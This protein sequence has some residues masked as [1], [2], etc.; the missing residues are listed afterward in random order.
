M[1]RQVPF[2][3][4]L[5][6]HNRCF[7]CR[8]KVNVRKLWNVS[9]TSI[10]KALINHS[11]VIPV[12]ARLCSRHIQDNVIK[13]H[14][15]TKIPT[16]LEIF[17]E[18]ALK[19]MVSSAK[20]SL[21]CLRT[22]KEIEDNLGNRYLFEPFR[23]LS[24]LLD[25]YCYEI[26]GWTKADLIRCSKYIRDTRDSKNRTIGML[27]AMY[28]FWL[29]KAVD[30]KTLSYLKLNS[31]QQH[32]SNELEQIRVKLDQFFTPHWIGFEG[33]NREFFLAHNTPTVME[34]YS[35]KKEDRRL[36]LFA[37]GGY[38]NNEKSKN[39]DLQAD[40]FSVQKGHNLVKPF[41]I[42]CADGYICDVYTDFEAT[43]NDDKI[44][45][46]ILLTDRHLRRILEKEDYLFLD[47]GFRDTVP[48]LSDEYGLNV[49]IPHCQQKDKNKADDDDGENNDSEQPKGKN[50]P[51]TSSQSSEARKCTK[52]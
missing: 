42:T 45:R 38:Q 40:T 5:S 41:I 12:G 10:S 51:F 6:H 47:R 19:S 27:I 36:C 29:R 21:K 9:Q 49:V 48:L 32:V 7:I 24:T 20:F 31:S 46:Q 14:E 16:R 23:N 28:R 44:F 34:L 37:D 11:I 13:D 33:K 17:D 43:K 2:Q 4:S 1:N 39:N 25:D 8:I 15:F 52:V 50:A 3:V 18:R 22:Q 35:I 30:Q 26:T